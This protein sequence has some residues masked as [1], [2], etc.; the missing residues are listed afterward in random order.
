M[1]HRAAREPF[2]PE[3]IIARGWIER[4]SAPDVD[5]YPLRVLWWAEDRSVQARFCTSL[6]SLDGRPDELL[7]DVAGARSRVTAS[8]DRSDCEALDDVVNLLV[9][10]GRS[11]GRPL[12][13]SGDGA[14][15]VTDKIFW[16]T[17]ILRPEREDPWRPRLSSR[18]RRKLHQVLGRGTQH[19][20]SVIG[21]VRDARF[22]CL[23][24]AVNAEDPAGLIAAGCSYYEYEPE[25]DEID[26]LGTDV[27][28][29][30]VRE[31][32]DRW[33]A[34]SHALTDD[35]AERIASTTHRPSCL[36]DA[37]DGPRASPAQAPRP[38]RR[39]RRR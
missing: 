13:L 26:S 9:E 32:F 19:L 18:E 16:G 17:G 30:H 24:A 35:A 15:R 21:S 20:A 22:E 8:P 29:A 12:Q 37:A 3:P 14:A 6:I 2:P 5:A 34:D 27:T 10:A 23:T 33:F 39:A 36:R 38:R 7:V 11:T 4:V 25:V 1:Q 31:I 28:A